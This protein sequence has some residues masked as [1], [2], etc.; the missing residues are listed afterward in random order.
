MQSLN[1]CTTCGTCA[2]EVKSLWDDFYSS[3]QV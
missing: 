3:R 1:I 2:Q